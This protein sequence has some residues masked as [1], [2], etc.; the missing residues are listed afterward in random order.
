MKR[1]GGM[2]REGSM[3]REGDSNYG[4]AATHPHTLELW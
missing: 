3:K 1:E 4:S 2:K